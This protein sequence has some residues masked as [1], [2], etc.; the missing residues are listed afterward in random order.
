VN[1]QAVLILPSRS[2]FAVR[3]AVV[4][5][6][7]LI[8][9]CALAAV[10]MR[11]FPIPDG[12]SPTQFPPAFVVSTILLIVGSISLS[13]AR[14]YVRRERQLQFRRALLIGLTAGTL[15]VTTQTYALTWLI[16]QQRPTEVQ[17]GAG[18]FVAVIASLHAMHFVVA[19]MFL[20]F[21]T[22]RAFADRYDHE[23]Y[24]G[25]TV[26]TWFWHALG[27]AWLVVLAVMMISSLPQSVFAQDRG[28]FFDEIVHVLEF[29]VNRC[30]ADKGDVIDVSQG[31][32]DLFAD[33]A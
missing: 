10:L 12:R 32:H 9:A 18:A 4:S 19:L 20:V 31:L 3:F 21:V 5:A 30:K 15:F 16:R 8:L 26:C 7:L 24:W 28:Q 11:I 23:Y 14:G 1:H 22:V 29:A 27:V 17:V 13:R 6:L 25:V 33:F 2:E